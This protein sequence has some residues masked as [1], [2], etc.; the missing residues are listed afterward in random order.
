MRRSLFDQ[1]RQPPAKPRLRPNFF[2]RTAQ[3]AMHNSGSVIVAALLLSLSMF[4]PIYS[5]LSMYRLINIIGLQAFKTFY[6]NR[7]N[8]LAGFLRE[9]I[10]L[11]AKSQ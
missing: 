11:Y 8:R 1:L 2:A 4:W 10:H 3:F 7:P 9:H 5:V 6:A